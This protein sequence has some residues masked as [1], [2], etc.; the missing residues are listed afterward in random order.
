MIQAYLIVLGEQG[1]LVGGPGH[2]LRVP[3]AI[4]EAAEGFLLLGCVPGAEVAKGGGAQP[5]DPSYRHIEIEAYNDRERECK[6]QY[7]NT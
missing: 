2:Q 6:M 3:G 5:L 7:R 1:L 4:D